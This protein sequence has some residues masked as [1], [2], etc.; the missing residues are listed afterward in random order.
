[1][2][3]EK[4][5]LTDFCGLQCFLDNDK[6]SSITLDAVIAKEKGIIFPLIFSFQSGVHKGDLDIALTELFSN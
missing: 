3:M 5:I 4:G 2:G 6:I 1:M